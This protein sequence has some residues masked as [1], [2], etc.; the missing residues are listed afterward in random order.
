MFRVLVVDDD[1]NTRF[2]IKEALELEN[3][4]VFTACNGEEALEIYDKEYIDVVI[5]DIMMPKMDG[6]E[7]TKELRS[8]NKDVIILMIS[9]KQL[10]EDR[11]KGFKAGIDDYLSKPIDVEELLLRIKLLLNRINGVGNK[12][13]VIGNVTV[14]YDSFTVSGYGEVQ[15]LPQKEFLL[16]Y[17][18][19]SSP[20]KIF[21]KIQL[22]DEIWGLECDTGWETV[23]VHIGRLRKRFENYSEFKI[24]N[25]RGLGYKAVIT[26]EKKN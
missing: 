11:I 8:V 6:Y 4:K 15:E 20:N 13:L 21:T 14:D 26:N 7:F 10:S 22:M 18:L 24:E 25:V 5:V 2:F 12:K 17:K 19:L 1:K 16:L 3:Y 23:V 9:A